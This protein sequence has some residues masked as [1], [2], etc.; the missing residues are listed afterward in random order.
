MTLCLPPLQPATGD[1]VPEEE[2]KRF[3][4]EFD[5]YWQKLQKAKEE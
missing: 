4:Q 1:L 3:E 5:D 2:R